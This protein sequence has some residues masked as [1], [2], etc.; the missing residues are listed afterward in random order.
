MGALFAGATGWWLGS[1]IGGG[2]ILLMCGLLMRRAS[3]PEVRQRLGEVGIVAAVLLALLRLGP[4]WIGIPDPWRCQEPTQ[5]KKVATATLDAVPGPQLAWQLFPQDTVTDVPVIAV[6]SDPVPAAEPLI[7]IPAC[8]PAPSVWSIGIIDGLLAGYAALVVF[9]LSRWIIAQIGL[10]AILRRARPAPEP[11]QQ[12]FDRLAVVTGQERVRLLI[13]DK[14]PVPMCCG[15]QHPTVVIPRSLALECNPIV[16]KW[17]FAHELTHLARRDPWSTWLLGMGQSLYFYLPWFWWVRRQ[18]RLC[19]EYIAD[20]AAAA[21]GEW[22]DDYAQFLVNLARCPG[23]PSGATGVLGNTSDLYRRIAMLLKP[24]AKPAGAGSRRQLLSGI[25][26]LFAAAVVLAG[27]GVRAETPEDNKKQETEARVDV[28]VV[29]DDDDKDDDTKK[30]VIKKRIQMIEQP[31]GGVAIAQ[32]F[33]KAEL[34]KRIRKAL[35]KA[36]LDN[37][38]VDKVIKEVTKSMEQFQAVGPMVF[39]R[40]AEA[41]PGMMQWKFAGDDFKAFP[42]VGEMMWAGAAPGMPGMTMAGG[43]RLG[44]MIERPSATLIEQLDLD[45]DQG[46]VVQQV[47]KGSAAEKAGLKANDILLRFADKPVGGDLQAFVKFIDGLDADREFD[48]VVLRKGRKET[49]TGIK[50]G[51]KKKPE[52]GTFRIITADDAAKF[53]D[54][55]NAFIEL[56]E[57]D[58]GKIGDKMKIIAE[59]KAK[60]AAEAAELHK[61]LIEKHGMDM[62]K[63]AKELEKHA[64]ELKKKLAN[65]EKEIAG[66]KLDSK[67]NRTVSVTIKDG[68]YS[69]KESDGDSTITVTGT[70]DDGKVK[71]SSIT[72]ID[73]DDKSTYKS[74]DKVPS[75]YRARVEK[76]I[77]NTGDSSVRVRVRDE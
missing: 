22:A 20:R 58:K 23:A 65:I 5:N 33:D 28:I 13:S 69:A 27:L 35:E 16:L 44:I 15:V 39:G 67:T 62:E 4:T 17:I 8:R 3:S 41:A 31:R 30:D 51:E 47:V 59:L 40:L 76:L 56:K 71:V 9:F 37:D 14:V 42:G 57:L 60:D 55:A 10:L 7:E 38:E 21:Q 77:A 11:V 19:Q 32:A 2:A 36:K 43:G 18:V 45:K 1:A 74:V 64:A 25:S 61:K 34:E 26:C 48:A 70:M 29:T 66:K 12:I 54:H 6:A 24:S 75:K 72:V 46:V 49:V 63:H 52:T 68:E 50:L 53:V 73:G